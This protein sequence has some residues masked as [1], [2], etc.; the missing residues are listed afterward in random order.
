M[1]LQGD[2]NALNTNLGEELTYR[3]KSRETR[4]TYTRI[5]KM[6]GS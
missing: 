6:V 2:L 1:H 3:P 4:E 5:M